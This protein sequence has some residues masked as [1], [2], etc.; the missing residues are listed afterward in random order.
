MLRILISTI[1]TVLFVSSASAGLKLWSGTP[2]DVTITGND[3]EIFA[4]GTFKF[5][6]EVTPGGALDVIGNIT[7]NSSVTGTV[8]VYIERDTD[9]DSPGATNVGSINLTNATTGDLAELRITGNLGSGGPSTVTA[10]TGAVVIGDGT[11]D[12][13]VNDFDASPGGVSGN[14]TIAGSIATGKQLKVGTM[15]GN[16]SVGRW[17]LGD[18][19]ATSLDGNLTIS[20]DSASGDVTIGGNYAD[21]ITCTA[22]GIGGDW[23]IGGK[24][25]G[26][27]TVRSIGGNGR[28]TVGG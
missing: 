24:L 16:I 9:N 5:E 14:I 2:G 8:T 4:A 11:T 25:T 1:A 28:L 22:A 26:T 17:L 12:N 13:L 15:A 21:T 3:A 23:S 27:V 6:S 7:V 20:G 19:V 18:I 10:V